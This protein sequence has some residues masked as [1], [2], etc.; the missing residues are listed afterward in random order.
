[1]YYQEVPDRKI[2]TVLDYLKG[3]LYYTVSIGIILV[4]I[5]S[6]CAIAWMFA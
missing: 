5:W 4:G 6:I 1:M 3:F 2:K